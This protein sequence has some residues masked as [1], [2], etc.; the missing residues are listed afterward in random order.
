MHL[1][2]LD[3][4]EDDGLWWTSMWPSIHDSNEDIEEEEDEEFRDTT[5]NLE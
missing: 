4:R 5:D 3:D 2:N 1:K